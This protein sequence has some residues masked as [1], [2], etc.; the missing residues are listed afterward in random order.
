MSQLQSL[1]PLDEF[2]VV[3]G[4]DDREE[5]LAQFCLNSATTTAESYCRRKLYRRNYADSLEFMGDYS[6]MLR[7]YP[8]SEVLGVWKVQGLEASEIVEP[9]LYRLSPDPFEPEIP[10]TEID[11]PYT[12]IASRA[13]K[14]TKGLSALRVH[15]A[16]GYATGEVPAD[17]AAACLE[18]AAWNMARYRGRRIGVLGNGRG[19]NAS[20]SGEQ[21]EG[22]MPENVKLLLEPYKRVLI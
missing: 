19:R 12:L 18:L 8:V 9:E 22:S 14:L 3:L 10:G 17:L 2:K 11:T 15:Y 5:A 13:L 16:A 21:F 20:T 7:Q 6:F 1:I 4:V